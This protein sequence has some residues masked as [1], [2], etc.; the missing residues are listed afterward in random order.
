[1]GKT[2][3]IR[4]FVHNQFDEKYLSTVG[5]NISSK[6]TEVYIP[7]TGANMGLKLLIWDI[8]G[9]LMFSDVDATYFRGAKGALVV[10]DI[11]NRNTLD[12]LPDWIY[13]FRSI[14]PDSPF[15]IL[16]NKSD[17]SNQG[18]FEPEDAEHI[19]RS[20]KTHFFLTSAKTGDGV[21]NAFHT[22]GVAIGHKHLGI[23]TPAGGTQHVQ[24]VEL[25]ERLEDR[26]Q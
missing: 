3:L 24:K 26:K 17:L 21:E 13:R 8:A 7:D 19:A 20:Y 5:T 1:V 6:D 4:R 18:Q 2:S 23:K 22:L 15:M 12:N 16:V 10:C 25:Y 14:C 11:T 9:Q